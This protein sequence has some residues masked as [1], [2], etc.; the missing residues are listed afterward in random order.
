MDTLDI[1]HRSAPKHM[2]A[3]YYV[4][5]HCAAWACSPLVVLTVCM[6]SLRITMYGRSLWATNRELTER[7]VHA[8]VSSVHYVRCALNIQRFETLFLSVLHESRGAIT[9]FLCQCALPLVTTENMGNSCTA[10]LKDF[11]R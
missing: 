3:L 8:P 7:V 9:T 5:F 6:S 4:S 10:T 1:C 2:A 11:V